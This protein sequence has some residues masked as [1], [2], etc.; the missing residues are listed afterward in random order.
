MIKRIGMLMAS[1]FKSFYAAFDMRDAF[2][3]GGLAMLWH[4]LNLLKGQGWAFAV[5]GPLLMV[6]GYFIRDK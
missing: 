5:C 3:L 1:P 6:I 2:L 4:G